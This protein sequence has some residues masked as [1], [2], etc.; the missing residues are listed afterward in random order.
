MSSDLIQLRRP[1]KQ[2]I[3]DRKKLKTIRTE[4]LPVFENVGGGVV[5]ILSDDVGKIYIERV[6]D[7]NRVRNLLDQ[8]EI[9]DEH[10]TDHQK[11]ICR[12]ARI[13][14]RKNGRHYRCN[15]TS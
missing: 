3:V 2:P 5:L 13:S 12:H 11:K 1:R 15:A 9:V 4:Q 10:S 8:Y 6:I 7:R 14:L